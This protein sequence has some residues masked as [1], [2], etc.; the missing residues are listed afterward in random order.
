MPPSVAERTYREHR[1]FYDRL[2]RNVA[3]AAGRDGVPDPDA[4][5][6]HVVVSPR[7]TAIAKRFKA[8]AILLSGCQDNQTSLD[9]D[10][11]GAFTEQL[12]RV[13]KRGSFR[14]NYVA[15]HARIQARMPADQ[16][17]NL[18]TLGS[19]AAFAAQRPFQI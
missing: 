11:N 18:F 14:G 4:M 13:W 1:T 10:R 8:A 9:G 12:L 19:A 5:L 2:Q 7:L 6:A 17:P 16:T 3:R 15:F